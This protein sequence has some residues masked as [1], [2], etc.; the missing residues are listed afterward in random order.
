MEGPSTA[1]GLCQLR[2]GDR[3]GGVGRE[4]L[5]VGDRWVWGERAVGREWGLAGDFGTLPALL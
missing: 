2:M 5:T 3:G 1:S 4:L